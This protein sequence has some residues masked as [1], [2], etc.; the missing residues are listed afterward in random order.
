V[1]IG[2]LLFTASDTIV[3]ASETD[4]GYS[5]TKNTQKPNPVTELKAAP[6]QSL[7][8]LPT[9]PRKK[10]AP[11]AAHPVPAPKPKP[12]STEGN[13]FSRTKAAVPVN[14]SP[15]TTKSSN[16]R[17]TQDH[18]T[19]STSGD[20]DEDAIVDWLEL[21]NLASKEPLAEEQKARIR[22]QLQH[23]LQSDRRN[24][25]LSIL[26]FWPAT[27]QEISYGID[28]K[29]GF[30]TLFRALLRF[31]SRSKKLAAE[32]S[33]ILPEVLGPERIA[34]PGDPPLTEDAVDAYA[35]MT[36]F[37]YEQRHPGKT[38]DAIDN[39]T[40]FAS[41]ICQNYTK[42]PSAAAKKAMANF[43]LSWAKFKIAWAD[44]GP[45][46]RD[47]LL[48]SL[49]AGSKPPAELNAKIVDMIITS[50]PWAQ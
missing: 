20:R 34:L 37:M 30:I 17:S 14:S 44:A 28:Q 49:E 36:C 46:Q 1:A 43:A 7:N 19:P 48:A 31:Q 16:S 50:G 25:V 5:D 6:A 41:V 3:C 12:K 32:D 10:T 8:A 13:Y 47:R 27:A 40:I 35:D 15:E 38:I 45:P 42:A 9:P 23:K 11:V 18:V 24:E 21:F 22:L 2:V 29:E 26:K 39:R 4:W 33:T